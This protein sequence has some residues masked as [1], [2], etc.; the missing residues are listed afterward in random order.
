MTVVPNV[1]LPWEICNDNRA[2]LA[3]F[4]LHLLPEK[5]RAEMPELVSPQL[6]LWARS[7]LWSPDQLL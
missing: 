2:S 7:L 5:G 4:R 1:L 3:H 6:L